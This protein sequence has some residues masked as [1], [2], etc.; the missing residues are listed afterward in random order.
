MMARLT[1]DG[2][3]KDYICFD[4]V[5]QHHNVI[6]YRKGIA[7]IKDNFHTVC[8]W[9]QFKNNVAWKYDLFLGIYLSVFQSY[10]IHLSSTSD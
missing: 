2:C 3:Q 10:Y 7:V 9:V 1:V 5:P 4:F 8:S 6:R